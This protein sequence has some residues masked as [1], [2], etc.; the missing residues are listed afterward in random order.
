MHYLQN[1]PEINA[2]QVGIRTFSNSSWAGPLAASQSSDIAFIISTAASGVAPRQ[3]DYFQDDLNKVSYEG[4][5]YPNWARATAFRYLKLT[6][7]FSIFAREYN[8]PIPAPYRD[9]YGQDFD[10]LT[11]WRDI[12]QPVLAINGQ[13]DTLIDPVDAVARFQ[14]TLEQNGHTDYTLVVWPNAD[15]VL[16]LT[17]TGLKPEGQGERD[18]VSAPGVMDFETSWVLDRFNGQTI[19]VKQ[20]QEVRSPVSVKISAHFEAGGRYDLLPWYGQPEPQVLLWLILVIVWLSALLTWPVTGIINLVRRNKAQHGSANRQAQI[21]RLLAWV[22]SALSLFLFV[23]LVVTWIQ[24]IHIPSG[25]FFGFP[26]WLTVL[27]MLALMAGVLIVVTLYFTVQAWR[28]AY[29]SKVG[30]IHYTAITITSILFVWFLAY[31]QLL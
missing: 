8:L 30:R 1:R 15:H 7:E 11:A 19:T 29:W 10:P 26:S 2:E 14:Q 20:S 13:Y 4:Y 5:D 17:D 23:G 12:T 16:R 28:K 21:A 31:W 3:A 9:Y 24:T 27:P 6:R 25:A 18:N 22:V